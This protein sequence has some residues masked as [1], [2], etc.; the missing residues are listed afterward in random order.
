MVSRVNT[1]TGRRY[2]DDPTIMA[3][4]AMNEPRCPG[5][6]RHRLKC[7]RKSPVTAAY[8]CNGRAVLPPAQG[9]VNDRW[10]LMNLRILIS[11]II[12]DAS[13]PIY[14]W[15]PHYCCRLH[16]VQAEQDLRLMAPD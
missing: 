1:F 15:K 6:L 13:L 10:H 3:Y 14:D 5:K 2:A 8:C 11:N 7:R 4:E 9:G 12:Y 16:V